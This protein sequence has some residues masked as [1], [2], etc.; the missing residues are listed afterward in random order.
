[1]SAEN[2]SFQ[3]NVA[4]RFILD[5]LNHGPPWRHVLSEALPLKNSENDYVP[6]PPPASER[7]RKTVLSAFVLAFAAGGCG[8]RAL[9]ENALHQGPL[10]GNFALSDYFTASGF[11]GDGENRGPL[12]VSRD[13]DC[14]PRW[15]DADGSCFRFVYEAADLGWAGVYFQYPANNWGS[16]PGRAIDDSYSSM[17][18]LASGSYSIVLPAGEGIGKA[19][20]EGTP[21][22][23]G[24]ACDA[25][26][27][28]PSHSTVE[29]ARCLVSAECAD[30]L[31]CAGQTCVANKGGL[32]NSVCRGGRDELCDSG[33]RCG[34][35]N[36][37]LVCLPDGANDVG[38]S[39]GGRN[40]CL[41]GL[42]CKKSGSEKSCQPATR[43]GPMRFMV[44]GIAANAANIEY[45]DEIGVE[46]TP[47]ADAPPSLLL[48]DFQRFRLD[49]SE[50]SMSS[51]I[52]GFMWAT[53]FP[54]VDSVRKD[55][56]TAYLADLTKPAYLYFDDLVFEAG[57]PAT[58]GAGGA[59]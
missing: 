45:S 12:T 14:A 10:S 8:P 5:F 32:A 18:F 21:C 50:S 29:G 57:S 24:L 41:A 34:E 9:S 53:A 4:A 54:D 58:T 36:G 42:I 39:C 16:E 7:V 20:S 44:G 59:Q 6:A 31:Q 48:P 28:A 3:K 2:S 43:L 46:Y 26:T 37:S 13:A 25:G 19:C 1:M 51:L 17:S 35:S 23:P 15:P 52:G 11:M 27:C 30:G 22:R 56:P 33:L 47:T 38:A 40:D 49:L 55:G